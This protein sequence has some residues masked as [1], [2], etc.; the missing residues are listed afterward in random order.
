MD[1]DTNVNTVSTYDQLTLERNKALADVDLLRNRII[2]LKAS[3]QEGLSDWAEN[4]LD[5][6]SA[7][8]GEL[9]D[10]MIDNDLEGLKRSYTVKVRVT[11]EFEVEVEAA[12]D[13]EARDEV[14]NDIYTHIHDNVTLDYY[15]DID[16]EATEA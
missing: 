1:T 2:N 6:G 4:N 16:I 13:D 9:S 12:N 5:S 7:A 15:E 8:Y 11:Y 10:L 3:L 14:D